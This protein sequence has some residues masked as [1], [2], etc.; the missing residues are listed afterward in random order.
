MRMRTPLSASMTKMDGSETFLISR[1]QE[2]TMDV[3]ITMMLTTILYVESFSEQ[4][5]YF[6]IQVYLVTG[7]Y[8]FD[9]GDNHNMKFLDTTEVLIKDAISWN[10][11]KNLPQPMAKMGSISFQNKIY[12]IGIR[13]A[14]FGGFAMDGF[15]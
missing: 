15:F 1:W 8:F 5:L 3:V 9:L 7:G 14:T 4:I 2:E 6:S 13:D 12:M 10:V 11:I